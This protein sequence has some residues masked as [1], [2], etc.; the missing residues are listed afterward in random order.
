[1]DINTLLFIGLAILLICLIVGIIHKIVSMIVSVIVIVVLAGVVWNFMPIEY[2]ACIDLSLAL[3]GS[4][5]FSDISPEHEAL[6]DETDIKVNL[7][8]AFTLAYPQFTTSSSRKD[9][10]TNENNHEF[11]I[12]L[13]TFDKN[14]K[15]IRVISS[16]KN[17]EKVVN[18]LKGLGITIRMP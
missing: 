6:L 13:F 1:M 17:A 4:K 2:K 16:P 15:S 11:D 8:S 14:L 18:V 10:I 3:T 7:N 9:P 5:F 12:N